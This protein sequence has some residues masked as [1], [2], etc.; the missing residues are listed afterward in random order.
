MDER[1]WFDRSQP[2]TLQITVWLLYLNAAFGLLDIL[3]Y[4][5]SGRWFALPGLLILAEAWGGFGIANERRI[6]YR[7]SLVCSALFAAFW[8]VALV[9]TH[10]SFNALVST[11]FS[12]AL[13]VALVHPVTRSYQK[14]WFR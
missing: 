5:V 3:I 4:G 9:I 2:Q 10:G 8:I 13:F 1:K 11:M 6:A 7:F 12:V 14:I